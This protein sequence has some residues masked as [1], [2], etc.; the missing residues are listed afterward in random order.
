A[1]EIHSIKSCCCERELVMFNFCRSEFHFQ[2]PGDQEKLMMHQQEHLQRLASEQQKIITFYNPGTA[3]NDSHE[4]YLFCFFIEESWLENLTSITEEK[5]E[6]EIDENRSLSSFELRMNTKTHNDRSIQPGT[7]VRQTKESDQEQLKINIQR[8]EQQQQISNETKVTAEKSFLKCGQGTAKLE[9]NRENLGKKPT[10]PLGRVSFDRQNNFSSSSQGDTEKLSGKHSQLKRQLSSPTV[11]FLGDKNTNCVISKYDIKTQLNNLDYGSEGRKG[12]SDTG[13]DDGEEAEDE[14]EF[15]ILSQINWSKCPD[16]CHEHISELKAQVT[17]ETE[18]TVYEPY[19]NVLQN[20]PIDSKVPLWFMKDIEGSVSQQVDGGAMYAS[21]DVLELH[22]G[23]DIQTIQE[24]QI[25]GFQV[26]EE[27]NRIRQCKT[28]YCFAGEESPAVQEEISP[29]FKK[30]NDQIVKVTPESDR[31]QIITMADSQR[32][33]YNSAGIADTWEGKSLSNDLVYTSTESENEPKSHCSQYPIKHIT[34]RAANTSKSIDLSDGDYATDEPSETEDYSLKSLL[35]KRSGGQQPTGQQKV[36]TITSSGSSSSES[37]VRDKTLFPLRKFPSHSLQ[38]ATGGREPEKGSKGTTSSYGTEFNLR[39]HSL[40]TDLVTSL[41]P[42]FKRKANLDNKRTTLEEAQKRHMSKLEECEQDIPV[43]RRET[44]LL[45]QMKEEQTKAM[46]FLRRQISQFNDFGPQKS[47]PAQECKRDKALKLQKEE[48]E[49]EKCAIIIKEEREAGEIQMLKQQIAGL[50]EK[51]RR[52]ETQWHAA[53]DELRSQVE[54]L[55]KQNLE[56]QNELGVSEHQKK[57]TER[58][59]GAV[60]FLPRKAETPVSAAILRGASS[61]ENLEEGPLQSSHKHLS[62]VHTGRKTPLDEFVPGDKMIK[63]TRSA[64][65]RSESLKS[66]TGDQRVKSPSKVLRSRSAMPTGR[67]TPHQMPSEVHSSLPQLAHH[68]HPRDGKNSVLSSSNLNAL[69]DASPSLYVKGTYCSTSGS[70]EDTA[71]LNSQNND[72]LYSANSSNV[73]IK[74]KDNIHCESTQKS[75][76]PSEQVTS[77]T[78]SRRNS[79]FSNGRKTPAENSPVLVDTGG[80]IPSLK[81]ILSRRASLYNESKEDG[82]VKEKIEYPDGKVKQV[83]MDGRRITTYPNGTKMEI[84]SDKRTTVVTFYNGDIKKI[85]PDQRVV[86]YYAD[87]QTTRTIFPGGLEM[88]Q[89]PNKQIGHLIS[90]FTVANYKEYSEENGVKTIQFCNGQKEIHT[91]A[92]TRREYPDGTVKTIYA[93]GQ[94]ETK[95]SSGH[96]QFKDEKRTILLDKK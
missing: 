69:R 54:A 39:H 72:R 56:L 38:V 59:Y 4:K 22:S 18:N 23:E 12:S 68:Q 30:V 73:E 28:E 83:F 2:S 13:S 85:L 58:K 35:S 52:N 81:P 9:K 37:S 88:L 95:C 45:A 24:N 14:K 93:N 49:A 15:C 33:H 92:F 40:T 62:N 6:Q 66:A 51:F 77:M 67:R 89:F 7:G 47:H 8:T 5:E 16:Q 80:K 82:V 46:D 60:D 25:S 64:L 74:G 20:G 11:L 86:Y 96:V 10:R 27:L 90:D 61:Q 19:H 32:K 76:K 48:A 87:A 3:E 26:T 70:S 41:F 31:K 44:S 50:Q 36:S 94:Q 71:F 17:E 34:H 42:M 53:H 63:A 91:A 57:E 65:Q 29:G 55:T 75:K 84:S 78:D 79:I 1:W 43:H 21:P